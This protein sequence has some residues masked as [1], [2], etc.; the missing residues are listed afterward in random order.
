MKTA[1]LILPNVKERENMKKAG[2]IL[3][4]VL[5]VAALAGAWIV[6]YFATKKMGMARY[7]IYKNQK[8]GREYPLE[9]IRNIV[10]AAVVICTVLA[11]IVFIKKKVKSKFILTMNVV[12]AALTAVYT[13]YS[14][15]S[16]TETMR[17]YYFIS[18]LLGIAAI[19]Q[20]IKTGVANLLCGEEAHEK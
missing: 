19:A 7:V 9:L 1:A 14:L 11:L 10:I 16:S 8:W 18:L 20:V 15:I 3:A 4:V 12:M 5:E 6:N 2:Y 17:A 13:G